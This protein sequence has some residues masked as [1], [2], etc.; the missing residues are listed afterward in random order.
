MEINDQFLPGAAS[1]LAPKE[2]VISDTNNALEALLCS[3]HAGYLIRQL[4]SLDDARSLIVSSKLAKKVVE[5]S[6][7]LWRS[8]TRSHF[9]HLYE[10]CLA[11]KVTAWRDAYK[12]A[13]SQEYLHPNHVKI[14]TWVKDGRLDLLQKNRVSYKE[15]TE[16]R[17][18][19][20]FNLIQ[21][22]GKK[23]H[24]DILNHY[25]REESIS[26]LDTQGNEQRHHYPDATRNAKRALLRLAIACHQPREVIE[27]AFDGYVPIPI[28]R[29]EDENL[30]LNEIAEFDNVTALKFYMERLPQELRD[31]DPWREVCN[32]FVSCHCGRS[33]VVT[34][35]FP[36]IVVESSSINVFK[37]IIANTPVLT[38]M[39]ELISRAAHRGYLEILRCIGT[40][41]GFN[42][43]KFS[44]ENGYTALM[45]A[46]HCR[47]V[48]IIDF[49]LQQGCSPVARDIN[50]KTPLHCAASSAQPAVV[51]RLLEAGVD[52]NA[53]TIGAETPLYSAIGNQY[54]LGGRENIVTVIKILLVNG[55]SIDVPRQQQPLL[56]KAIISSR[57]NTD[58]VALLLAK[59]ASVSSV[60]A[61]GKTP[62]HH[63]AREWCS[64]K[65]LAMLLAQDNLPINTLDRNHLTPL[66]HAVK[67]GLYE[68]VR[69]LLAKGARPLVAGAV[70]CFSLIS[71]EH[72]NGKLI[73]SLLDLALHGSPRGSARPHR[74]FGS[75]F[76]NEEKKAVDT[77]Y[78]VVFNNAN[79][80]DLHGKMMCFDRNNMLM[81]WY[82]NLKTFF[83]PNHKAGLRY[84]KK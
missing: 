68:N 59:G 39:H 58:I 57:Q 41:E 67:S 63:A 14:F 49:L 28:G 27:E 44:T 60:D 71:Y 24:Q 45:Y 40:I 79:V 26:I 21:W 61:E 75:P 8:I 12:K 10:E 18:E 36:V 64:E 38:W 56:A 13:V 74:F 5:N 16:I 48:C 73:K 15:M 29:E 80:E 69:A 82:R 55:A 83:E 77:L 9:P 72:S 52:V 11:R 33:T 37:H 19:R 43:S 65:M 20:G 54:P 17:D 6:D 34:S 70:D 31:G 30:V 4:D 78:D 3:S 2:T 42:I 47:W 76:S 1:S 23:K 84:Q 81:T 35:Q 32:K 53:Q 51:S 25:Y 7:E 66:C 22:A 46:A 50:R 62:L